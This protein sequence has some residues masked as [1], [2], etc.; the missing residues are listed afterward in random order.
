MTPNLEQPRLVSTVLGLVLVIGPALLLLQSCGEKPSTPGYEDLPRLAEPVAK[1]WVRGNLSGVHALLD[2]MPWLEAATSAAERPRS[3]FVAPVDAYEDPA[4]EEVLP[5]PGRRDGS[6]PAASRAVS[7]RVALR[8]PASL[9]ASRAFEVL[10]GFGR[11]FDLGEVWIACRNASDE[12]G[13]VQLPFSDDYGWGGTL[14]W[15][16]DQAVPG[17]EIPA[18]RVEVLPSEDG[19][20]RLRD[21]DG[22]VSEDEIWNQLRRMKTVG[23]RKVRI[24]P[25]VV[26]P[27][28][29]LQQL[30]VTL[31]RLEAEG[32]AS[33]VVS[34]AKAPL[35]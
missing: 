29:T 24:L 23:L 25:V 32:D 22:R 5:L 18:V 27:S 6:D 26:D 35:R 7:P 9:P 10:M 4:T 11:T 30:L 1:S 19:S 17:M 31:L 14:S 28:V 21:H 20:G 2:L 8:L 13:W 34:V 12:C 16:S 15:A 3:G 33:L